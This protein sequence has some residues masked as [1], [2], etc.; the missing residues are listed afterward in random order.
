M[1][2]DYLCLTTLQH[3]SDKSTG[4]DAS[5]MIGPGHCPAHGISS[6]ANRGV[7]RGGLIQ[8][9]RG[10]ARLIIQAQP[11]GLLQQL[12]L[13]GSSLRRYCASLDCTCTCA[14][15]LVKGDIS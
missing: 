13:Y 11:L 6:I 3:L 1:L 14:I 4:A 12:L 8:A 5:P 7:G 9:H 10:D 15:T 2:Q